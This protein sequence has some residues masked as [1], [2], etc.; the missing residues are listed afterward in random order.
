PRELS[1]RL[2][3]YNCPRDR[4]PPIIASRW[5]HRQIRE[6]VAHYVR[7]Q[8]M[9]V[10]PQVIPTQQN[11]IRSTSTGSYSKR[12]ADAVRAQ[13]KILPQTPYPPGVLKHRQSHGTRTGARR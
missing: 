9:S 10:P 4:L 8:P 2:F 5:K 1:V 12:E 11:E 6:G 7:R 3:H 13:A